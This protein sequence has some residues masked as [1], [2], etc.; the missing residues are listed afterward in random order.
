MH[1]FE[2]LVSFR[3]DATLCAG[4]SRKLDAGSSFSSY[5]WSNGNTSSYIIVNDIGLYSVTVTDS[6]GCRGADTTMVTSLLPLPSGFLPSDT[7]I[8]SYGK[9][10][11]QPT[12]SFGDYLWSNNSRSPAITVSQP[13]QYWLRVT[14]NNNCR[15][16][17][18]INVWGKDCMK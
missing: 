15:G 17:D 9:I 7:A 1:H 6:H 2:S 11:L 5:L 14:D 8:C 16:T 13:G 18:T 4:D 10:E 3:H 12:G